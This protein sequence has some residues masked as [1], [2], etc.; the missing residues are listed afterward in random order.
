MTNK[1]IAVLSEI[2]RHFKI[3]WGR[4][5]LKSMNYVLLIAFKT[6]RENPVKNIV[7]HREVRVRALWPGNM[8]GRS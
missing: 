2:W 3:G 5:P 6:E 7:K 4:E 1:N 8:S